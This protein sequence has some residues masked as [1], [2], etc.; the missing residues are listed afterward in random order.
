[1]R[2][3]KILFS[4]LMIVVLIY[5]VGLLFLFRPTTLARTLPHVKVHDTDV[6]NKQQLNKEKAFVVQYGQQ[7]YLGF[8]ERLGTVFYPHVGN[9]CQIVAVLRTHPLDGKV[10]WF[11][12]DYRTDKA[13]RGN[14][15]GSWFMNNIHEPRTK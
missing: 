12:G 1:M 11:L 10:M 3:G 6:F 7:N 15:L 8:F 5:I 9:M 4:I 14:S 2:F 13:H